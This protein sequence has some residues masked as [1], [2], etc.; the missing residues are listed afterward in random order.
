MGN[1]D[2]RI[3]NGEAPIIYTL[4]YGHT[5]HSF[6]LPK[7]LQAARIDYAADA[8]GAAEPAAAAHGSAGGLVRVRQALAEPLLCR[9]LTEAA[10]G[11]ES[12]VILIS[13]GTRL[14]PSHLFV[15]PLID[16]L[17]GAGIPD[18][19]ITVV[20]ALGMHR[21]ETEAELRA[22]AG[23]AAYGRVRVVNHSAQPADCVFLGTTRMGTPV[24]INR[25]VAEAG[26]R[27]ATG[28]IE[29]HPLVGMS[30]GV[31]AMVPG[32]ASHRTIE[33]NHSLS[34]RYGPAAGD[35]DHPI[36]R[37]LAE[38]ASLLA[39]DFLLNVVVDADRRIVFA[40]A[41][42]PAAAREA[43]IRHAQRLFLVPATELYDVV[44]ASP[45]GAPKD[46]Q[47]YQTVKSLQNA[48]AIAKP[49][50]SIVLAAECREHFGNGLLQY[51]M[52]TIPNREEAVRRLTRQFV[53]GPHKITTIQ[54]V[55]KQQRIFL[56]SDMPDPL[57]ELTGCRPVSNLQA[58]IDRLVSP[59]GTTVGWMPHTALTFPVKA[60]D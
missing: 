1:N 46:R 27:I 5:T 31:K 28:N 10:Q 39:L 22:L 32:T 47:F 49:G 19:R 11:K 59:P 38:A 48:A 44:I 36:Y 17:N 37:D 29:P 34:G 53:L 20:V 14:V 42:Q 60:A 50:G 18:T 6:T 41:G 16:E 23:P 55:L 43:C 7:P 54:S 51:W 21:K 35:P 57:V 9:P 26:F 8:P 30:G 56:Y 13:D 40:A 45:G 12:A 4:R 2:R 58:C 24:E 33:A 3:D 15:E 25:T 52:E